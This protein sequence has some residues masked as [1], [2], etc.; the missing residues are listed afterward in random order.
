[1]EREKMDNPSK[2]Y[3]YAIEGIKIYTSICTR[4]MFYVKSVTALSQTDKK[5]RISSLYLYINESLRYCQKSQLFGIF[6][7]QRQLRSG[8]NKFNFIYIYITKYFKTN[9]C[10][11]TRGKTNDLTRSDLMTP[12]YND[13][14]EIYEDPLGSYSKISK[15]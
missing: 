11:Q 8:V 3:F 4:L 10:Q 9:L 7:T 13:Q 2:N 15:S 6:R 12:L 1:M 14:R 5:V